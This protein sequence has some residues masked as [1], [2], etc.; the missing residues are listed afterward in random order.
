MSKV[1]T[2]A[3]KLVKTSFVLIDDKKKAST[4]KHNGFRFEVQNTK[5]THRITILY[6]K[7]KNWKWP[8]P[9]LRNAKNA[10]EKKAVIL[11]Q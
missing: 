1:L 8:V 10:Y 5:I 6:S 4:T 9:K 11:S 2:L 3:F 7:L